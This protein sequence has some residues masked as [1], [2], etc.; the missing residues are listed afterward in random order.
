MN[1]KSIDE[2]V[3]WMNE[4]GQFTSLAQ[5]RISQLGS[6]DQILL[7]AQ[8]LPEE[9]LTENTYKSMGIAVRRGI[10]NSGAD[11]SP[12][13]PKK[14]M[15]SWEEA[16]S[17]GK[18]DAA[19]Y[20]DAA[21]LE[22]IINYLDRKTAATSPELSAAE[23]LSRWYDEGVLGD[24][25][26]LIEQQRWQ[27]IVDGK[28]NRLGANNYYEEV[29]Y[30]F[31]PSHQVTVASSGT[32]AAPAG[33]YDTN[34]ATSANALQDFLA[35]KEVLRKKGYRITRV[36]STETAKSV[37]MQNGKTKTAIFPSGELRPVAQGD[38]DALLAIYGVPAWQTYEATYEE[39]SPTDFNV[40]QNLS[41][42]DRATF[43]PI[44]LFG[45]TNLQT[46]IDLGRDKGVMTFPNRLGYYA[47]GRPEGQ[48][49]LGKV[50][51]VIVYDEKYP[52]SVYGEVIA[53]GLPVVESTR[54]LESII[55]I[56]V[57]KPT[58]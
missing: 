24:L 58:P 14:V 4:T 47:L 54:L 38:V 2:L 33:W 45:T 37:F 31:P 50:A 44:V 42:L 52:P 49:Q 27:M 39:P 29:V 40:I 30:P 5:S 16:A 23:I 10:G 41:Y 48:T 3:S 13:Q 9:Q 35:Q 57:P 51:K 21:D 19:S 53:K 55:V 6:A 17:L 25:N 7:G 32:V 36:V 34:P 56:K 22:K 26:R 1:L 46:Q 28:V 12:A 18:I 20:L 11:L 43:D 15:G 8:I